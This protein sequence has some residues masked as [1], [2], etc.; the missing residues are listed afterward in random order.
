MH[1]ATAAA[2]SRGR[3]GRPGVGPR[4]RRDGIAVNGREREREKREGGDRYRERDEAPRDGQA[5]RNTLVPRRSNLVTVEFPRERAGKVGE[6]HRF[7]DSPQQVRFEMKEPPLN[8][9]M[10]SCPTSTSRDGM[11]MTLDVERRQ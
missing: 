3:S 2:C 6:R 9:E 11:S 10:A 7:C 8:S 4:P 5:R 1:T